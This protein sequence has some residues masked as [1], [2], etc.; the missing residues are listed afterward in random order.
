MK[1]SEFISVLKGI[2]EDAGG[3]VE[4]MLAVNPSSPIVSEIFDIVAEQLPFIKAVKVGES[5][6]EVAELRYENVILLLEG[7]MHRHGLSAWW[8]YEE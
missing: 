7:D 5:Y 6:S 4:V 2:E 8:S 1:L 3:D